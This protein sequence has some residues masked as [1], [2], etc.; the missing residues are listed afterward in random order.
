MRL[1]IVSWNIWFDGNLEKVSEFLEKSRADFIGLQEVMR[2]DKE[3]QL[4]N[5][6][7]EESGYGYFYAPAFQIQK[8][9]QA[10]EVGNLIL[11]AFPVLKNNI[12]NI[13]R[14][15]KRIAIET[16]VKI[17]DNILHI[18]CTHLLHTHQKPSLKQEEQADNLIKI[19]AKTDT[20]LMGD[21]NALPESRAVRKIS[22]V[23]NNTD[24][25]S[26]PTWSTTP[27]GCKGCL[28]G[29]LNFKL[30]YIFTSHDLKAGSFQVENSNA[31]DH[32]PISAIIEV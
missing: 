17:N 14:S 2:K 29:G 3:I 13:S 28:P 23:L 6:L 8:K 12:Y 22:S 5:R 19:I 21:F 32:L 15:D 11:S 9:G 16:D 30:D 24:N 26:R 18:V 27:Q 10:V 1:K 4:S 20:V 25:K 31:S 7:L